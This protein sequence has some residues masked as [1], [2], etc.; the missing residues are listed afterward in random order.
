MEVAV[1][2][3]LVARQGIATQPDGTGIFFEPNLYYWF[4]VGEGTLQIHHL[5]SQFTPV[6]K[7]LFATAGHALITVSNYS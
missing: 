6:N 4:R 1:E 2:T 3:S 7:E 5:N